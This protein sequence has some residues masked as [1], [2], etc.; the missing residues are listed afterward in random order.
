M[1]RA[2]RGISRGAHRP[3][4][5]SFSKVSKVRRHREPAPSQDSTN[6]SYCCW[7]R[8]ELHTL[9]CH[10]PSCVFE[11]S[12]SCRCLAYRQTKKQRFTKRFNFFSFYHTRK[13]SGQA[14]TSRQ[15]EQSPQRTQKRLSLVSLGQYHTVHCCRCRWH[16]VTWSS[17]SSFELDHTTSLRANSI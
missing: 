5:L 17:K 2:P 10:S 11:G 1:S 7:K 3:N 14:I 4:L 13:K 8:H 9:C 16:S 12:W 6:R 15:S